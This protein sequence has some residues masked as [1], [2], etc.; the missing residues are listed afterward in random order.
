MTFKE[1]TEYR[2]VDATIQTL[3]KHIDRDNKLKESIVFSG[4]KKLLYGDRKGRFI[5]DNAFKTRLK[6]ECSE[7]YLNILKAQEGML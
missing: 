5:Q 4:L 2:G 3:R 1:A 6:G 7:H